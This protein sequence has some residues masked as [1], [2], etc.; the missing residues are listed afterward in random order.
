MN[1]SISEIK[2]M[3]ENFNSRIY[4]LEERI[5]GIEDKNFEKSPLRQS[6][7]KKNEKE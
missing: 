1:S 5:S 7:E 2:N 3:I 4:Q 6:K